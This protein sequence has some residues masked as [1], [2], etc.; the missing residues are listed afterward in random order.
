MGDDM[1]ME[2]AEG[3]EVVGVVISALGP[4]AHVVGLEPIPAVTAID[5]AATVTPAHETANRWWYR[6]GHVR[7]RDGFSVGKTD[8]LDP[9]TA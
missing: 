5:G 4:G 3:G 1:V 7:C 6:S 8:N 9:P 2:P